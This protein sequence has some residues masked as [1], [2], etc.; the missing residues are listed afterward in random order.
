[1]YD[2][3]LFLHLLAAF[4]LV[5]GTMCLV[6]HAMTRAEGPVVERLFKTGGILAAVGGMGTLIFGLLLVWDA[7][8][9]FFTFWIIGALV[10]WVVGTGTGERTNRV[11]RAQ[12]RPLLL[13]S[14][15]AVL[16]ILI[17]MIWKPGA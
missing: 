6:P 2:L 4:V 13:I 5:A 15:L 14:S 11:E 8:Y 3:L 9:K 1:M 7:D 10:L 16:G 17:L 12:A